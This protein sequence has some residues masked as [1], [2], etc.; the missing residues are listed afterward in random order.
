MNVTRQLLQPLLLL[1]LLTTCS[2]K[3]RNLLSLKLYARSKHKHITLINNIFSCVR[4]LHFLFQRFTRKHTQTHYRQHTHTHTHPQNL[5][6]QLVS[7]S[8]CEHYFEQVSR[9]INPV[10][11]SAEPKDKRTAAS[12]SFSFSFYF[13]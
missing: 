5:C 6:P 3:N 9:T 10:G 12:F 2:M 1:L 13:C 11:N 4:L 8:V 7:F